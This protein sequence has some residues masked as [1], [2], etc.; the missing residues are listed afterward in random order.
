MLAKSP[1]D[2]VPN[3]HIYLIEVDQT[4]LE[5]QMFGNNRLTVR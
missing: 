5:F 4:M 2:S 1:S 3:G